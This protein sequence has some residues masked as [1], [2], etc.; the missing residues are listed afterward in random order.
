MKEARILALGGDGI[1][2]EVLA[3]GIEVAH[4]LCKIGSIKLDIEYD[5]IHGS[6]YEKYGVFC[7]EETIM[8]ARESDAVLVGAVGGSEWDNIEIEGGPEMQDGLMRLRK[9]LDC[10]IGLRPAKSWKGLEHLSSLKTD[11]LDETNI[12]VLREMTGGVMFASPRGRENISGKRYAFDTAAYNEDEISRFAHVGFKIARQRNK[13]LFSVDKAN[14]MES[15]ILWREIVDEVSKEYPD[16][17]LKHLYADNCAYQMIKKPNNF[18]VILSCNFLG[19]LLSDL[20]GVISGSLGMLPS[21]C[22][23]SF[24][25]PNEPNFGI[26]EPVHGSAPDLVGKQVANPIGMILSVGMMINYSFARSDLNDI[27][28]NAIAKTL[29]NGFL[30]DDLG[31]SLSTKKMTEKI[32]ENIN[33]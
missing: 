26:Y 12:L 1:G 15:Y 31:G 25:N 21:A 22:L 4:H 18:D 33:Q 17:E 11:L 23:S 27:L 20:S 19:D 32:C 5:L 30:T 24:N 16:V 9:S 8:K 2:P 6:C 10:F 7:R 28:I 29:N 13:C 14:V 3:S